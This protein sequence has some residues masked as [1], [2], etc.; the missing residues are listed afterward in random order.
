MR[1]NPE[2]TRFERSSPPRLP[3]RAIDEGGPGGHA[4]PP[5]R[6]ERAGPEDFRG[7]RGCG[8]RGGPFF[9]G[10]P[11]DDFRREPWNGGGRGGLAP[12]PPDREDYG[13]RGGGRFRDDIPGI[14]RGGG[15]GGAGGGPGGREEC[16]SRSDL[17]AERARVS[18]HPRPRCFVYPYPLSLHLYRY[19]DLTLH[20]RLTQQCL[21]SFVLA[22]CLLLADVAL[23]PPPFS[24]SSTSAA[25]FLLAAE[26]PHGISK[27]C[28][29]CHTCFFSKP[30]PMRPCCCQHPHALN[31][32]SCAQHALIARGGE[33]AAARHTKCA[34]PTHSPSHDN[35]VRRLW[36]SQTPS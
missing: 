3:V 18:L 32:F 33:D 21:L 6:F 11:P 4:G 20:A 26:K 16:L 10:A 34:L 7:G 30:L 14:G 1:R 17:A 8:G 36:C 31:S 13:R 2:I 9:R 12:A 27:P 19:H 24:V 23:T 22:C 28:S 5:S 35:T 15:S 29:L 25:R